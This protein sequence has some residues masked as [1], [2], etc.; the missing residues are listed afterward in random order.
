MVR[1]HGEVTAHTAGRTKKS[2]LDALADSPD[3]LVV[4]L[5]KVSY[6]SPG[7]C[8]PLFTALLV[9]RGAGTL[10][11]IARAGDRAASTLRQ[12]G[13]G[14]LLDNSNFES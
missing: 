11:T 14:R 6:L 9:A 13:L 5:S 12:V 1:L 7:G 10:L 4:D 3:A 2:L 8:S